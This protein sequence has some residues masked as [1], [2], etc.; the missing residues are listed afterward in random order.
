MSLSYRGTDQSMRP[1][2]GVMYAQAQYRVAVSK[3]PKIALQC[4][5]SSLGKVYLSHGCFN[6]MET[7]VSRFVRLV[8]CCIS[9]EHVETKV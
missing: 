6:S 1:A 7:I 9:L 5:R 2:Y 3:S 4:W 8:Y